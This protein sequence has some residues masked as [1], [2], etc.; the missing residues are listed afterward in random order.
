MVDIQIGGERINATLPGVR[1]KAEAISAQE[2]LRAECRAR[3]NRAGATTPLK[4]GTALDRYVVEHLQPKTQR[5]G[6]LDTYIIYLGMVRDALGANTPVSTITNAQLADWRAE[7]VG[8]VQPNTAKRYLTQCK[9]VL[10]FARRIG[11]GNEVPTFSPTVPSDERIR[12]L[13]EDEEATLLAACPGWLADLVTF[14][15]NTGAR[16]ADA[17]GLNVA[18]RAASFL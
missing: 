16:E 11:G 2:R 13:T 9:A 1:T 17:P 15:L 8:R 10:A 6:S 14:Y 4:L 12:W 3:Q 18:A 5:P 7:L